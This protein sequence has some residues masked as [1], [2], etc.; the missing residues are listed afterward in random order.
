MNIAAI[1]LGL[2]QWARDAIK[3]AGI[4]L[5][6]ILLGRQYVK[7]KQNEAVAA[8]NARRDK[9][10]AEVEREVVTNIQENTDVVI[11]KAD[12]VRSHTAVV[13]LPDGTKSLP[14]YHYRD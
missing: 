3:I 7:G 10:A 12:A 8:N 5:G 6:L 13:E 9:E 4:V 11:A 2:P 1:W 14:E